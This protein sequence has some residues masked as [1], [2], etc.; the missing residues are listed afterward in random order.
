VAER[1]KGAKTKAE[2]CRKD[3]LTASTDLVPAPVQLWAITSFTHKNKSEGNAS[4]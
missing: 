1:E 3:L 2:Q 4:G